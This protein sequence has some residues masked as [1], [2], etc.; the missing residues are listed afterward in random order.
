MS[1]IKDPIVI[2]DDDDDV[3]PSVPGASGGE[4]MPAPSSS[5]GPADGSRAGQDLILIIYVHG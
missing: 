2:S 4:H 5:T 3:K 1:S